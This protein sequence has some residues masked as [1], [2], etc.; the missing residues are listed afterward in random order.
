MKETNPLHKTLLNTAL[1]RAHMKESGGLTCKG[2]SL[3]KL[4]NDRIERML[5]ANED[6]TRAD[7]I[8]ELAANSGNAR[9]FGRISPG[10]VN[11]ILT[12]KINCPP[13]PRLEGFAEVLD[14]P[15]GRLIS[16]AERDG[17]NIS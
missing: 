5:N 7:I 17:C 14:L 15:I 3:A 13:R 1:E 6:L 2:A 12:G 11:E 16:A 9:G 4:M 10:T 8:A